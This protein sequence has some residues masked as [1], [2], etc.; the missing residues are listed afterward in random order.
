MTDLI[1]CTEA[2]PWDKKQSPNARV[3]HHGAV[4]IKGSTRDGYPGG[5]IVKMVCNFCHHDWET[6]LPQ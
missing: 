3:R 4:E 1:E 6:E 5:D 2:R